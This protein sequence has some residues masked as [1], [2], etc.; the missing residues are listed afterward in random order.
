MIAKL[1]PEDLLV[2]HA[3][4]EPRPPEDRPQI[5]AIGCLEVRRVDECADSARY[6]PSRPGGPIAG[7]TI[8]KRLHCRDYENSG[9]YRRLTAFFTYLIG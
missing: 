2:F 8:K 3:G 7:T 1:A 9:K 6:E 5:Y 4:L